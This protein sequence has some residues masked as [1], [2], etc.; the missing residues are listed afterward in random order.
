MLSA[1][2]NRSSA[3][4]A[5]PPRALDF[6]AFS[7]R[8][9]HREW[10]SGRPRVHELVAR[11]QRAR[12]DAADLFAEPL[13]RLAEGEHRAEAVAVGPDVGSKQEALMAA[14][15]GDKR[16]PVEGHRGIIV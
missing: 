3:G 6:R 12:D 4:R 15:E 16:G 7:V 9:A 2:R 8:T 5:P 10:R 11:R 1:R 13:Q 14:D